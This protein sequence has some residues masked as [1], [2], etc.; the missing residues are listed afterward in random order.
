MERWNIQQLNENDKRI[1]SVVAE[2]EEAA[3]LKYASCIDSVI[4][5]R[6]WQPGWKGYKVV[7]LNA[8]RIIKVSRVGD[9]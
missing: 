6:V 5:V 7:T 4:T 3:A 8:Y 9:I 2:N 1:I